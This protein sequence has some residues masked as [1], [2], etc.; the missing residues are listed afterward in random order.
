MTY[1]NELILESTIAFLYGNA[2]SILNV[3]LLYYKC[4]YKYNKISRY[5]IQYLV[6]RFTINSKSVSEVLII[7]F[8]NNIQ[9]LH[10]PLD[11]LLFM[12]K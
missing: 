12:A 9:K 6:Y 7:K 11:Y 5:L 1:D 4:R 10:L 2:A 8:F 3:I